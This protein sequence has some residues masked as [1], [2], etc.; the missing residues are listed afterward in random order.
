MVFPTTNGGGAGGNDDAGV[1]SNTHLSG[2][3]AMANA[4]TVIADLL[5]HNDTFA[6]Q[7]LAAN[8]TSAL[9]SLL[10]DGVTEATKVLLNH[11]SADAAAT[12]FDLSVS[13][14]A[15]SAAANYSDDAFDDDAMMTEETRSDY[16]FDRTYV[17]VIFI[18][19]YAT[20]FCGCVF[21]ECVF[22]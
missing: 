15:S 21:G 3:T 2:E 17:R 11:S 13:T 18:T 7:L 6:A 5:L 22:L 4:T 1:D 14:T 19:F 10:I 8:K 12:V 9:T 16:V 20:V